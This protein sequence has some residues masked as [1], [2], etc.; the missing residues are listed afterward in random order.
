MKQKDI[1]YFL[2]ENV[3]GLV[4][5][6]NGKSLKTIMK[7]LDEAGYYVKWQVLNSVHYGVPQMR[8]RIYFV[9]FRKDLLPK[10]FDFVFPNSQKQTTKVEDFL[11]DTNE[12]TFGEKQQTYQTFIKYLGNKYNKDKHSIDALLSN[13]HLVLDT[14]QS[15]IRLYHNK[16][17]TLRL[18]RHGILYVRDNKFRKLS[19]YESILLQ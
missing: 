12:L 7:S 18:G 3:K 5:H 2:L 17:P 8:E 15:D 16:V 10:D 14:R 4:N 6:D 1:K 9:G 11:I 13:E 19:G